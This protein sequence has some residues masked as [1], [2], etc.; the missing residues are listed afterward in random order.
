MQQSTRTEILHILMTNL[1]NICS[2]WEISIFELTALISCTSNTMLDMNR[3]YIGGERW[4]GIFCNHCTDVQLTGYM[5]D[6]LE[7]LV[8][9][10]IKFWPFA[11]FI[12][13]LHVKVIQIAGHERVIEHFLIWKKLVTT[14]DWA[15]NGHITKMCIDMILKA[16]LAYEMIFAHGNKSRIFAT[17]KT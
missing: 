7:N 5:S 17:H 3:P 10:L 15:P 4:F 12:L 1:I 2:F 13:F 16:L 6:L 11:I 14:I 8:L 9:V